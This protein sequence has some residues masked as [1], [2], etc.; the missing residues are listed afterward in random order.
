MANNIISLF[1]T[2]SEDML[3]KLDIH[4]LLTSFY[5][6]EGNIEVPLELEDQD[7]LHSY[8]MG[9]SKN[10]WDPNINNLVVERSFEIN[11]PK[12]LFGD[13]GITTDEGLLGVGVHVYSRSSNFQT[14]IPINVTLS[15]NSRSV[16]V[17]FRHEFNPAQIK[18]EVDF[19][20][21]VYLK[22]DISYVPMF[23][24]IPGIKLGKLDS[25]K[26]IVDGDG[27]IFPVVEVE[28]LDEP[29]WNVIINWTDINSDSFDT[30]NVRI[31]I[32]SKHHMYGYIYKSTK[33]S[34]YLLVEIFSNALSQIIFRAVNDDDFEMDGEIIP[35]SIASV[36]IYWIQTF[37]VNVTSYESINYSL[38][39]KIEPL[40]M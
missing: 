33:A 1:K 28:K 12:I 32:N 35:N 7:E 9:R 2:L 34:Q 5:Y 17:E 31:E 16:L 3:S 22:N 4:N 25:F 23:A 24:S 15:N 39:K 21:F 38:R 40:F 29:L 8:Y 13:N 26:I 6:R 18:G 37:E 10:F 11:N 19:S 36:V 27:S 30:D 14:T 20:L